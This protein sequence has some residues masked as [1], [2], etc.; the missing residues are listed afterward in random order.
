MAH[1]A[2]CWRERRRYHRYRRGVFAIPMRKP[3]PPEI[4]IARL[5]AVVPALQS[6]KA[7]SLSIDSFAPEVQRWALAQG[8]DY[9]NDIHGFAD[10]A[11]Y[12]ALAQ[13]QSQADRD[14]CGAGARR[15]RAHRCACRTKS[16]T[17]S[18][19]SSMQRIAA[20]TKAG[21]ARERLILDP[22][23][24]L[25]LGT[26]SGKLA[27]PAAPP[28]G[29]E[30]PFWPA[31]AGLGLAQVLPAQAGRTGRRWKPA[32]PAWRPNCSPRRRAPIISAPM[33]RAPCGMALRC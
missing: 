30:G 32:R 12:P 10:A 9:L 18:P 5:A 27:D 31:A 15:R 7:L 14:A 11:L 26:R 3:V 19:P 17:A 23:M 8:V 6:T 25:F 2:G 13:S 16:S 22:G 28:A 1:A 20:L 21:I 33:P 4:E 24:G 29:A